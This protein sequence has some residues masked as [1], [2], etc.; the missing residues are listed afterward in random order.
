MNGS[1]QFQIYKRRGEQVVGGSVTGQLGFGV[2]RENWMEE[3]KKREETNVEWG[4][5]NPSP[6]ARCRPQQASIQLSASSFH[7]ALGQ[8]L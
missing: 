2:L 4:Y 3:N 7:M 5:P 1:A 8:A 6:G